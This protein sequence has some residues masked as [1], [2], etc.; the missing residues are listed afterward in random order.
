MV[1]AALAAV[2]KDFTILS[3]ILSDTGLHVINQ[4]VAHLIK[5]LF[6]GSDETFNITVT[7]IFTGFYFYFVFPCCVQ[8]QFSFSF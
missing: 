6:N 2:V 3:E 1:V 4:P 7:Q 5:S 8:C